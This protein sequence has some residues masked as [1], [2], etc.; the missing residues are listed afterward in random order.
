MPRRSRIILSGVPAHI[1]QRGNNRQ[2]CFF[3]DQDRSFFL[4]HFGRWLQP[5][6]CALHAYCLMTNHIHLLLTSE[7]EDGCARLMKHVG[8]LHAQ[9]VN[10][11]Y[12]RV[13]TLWQGRFRSCVVQSED[14][15][16]ACYR[17]IESNP[18]RA[19]LARHPRDYPWS[20]YRA[21]AE[22][23]PDALL[24]PHDDYLRLGTSQGERLRAYQDLFELG[25]DPV[26]IDEI[27]QA[28]NGNFALG[29]EAFKRDM[30]AALGRRVEPGKAGRPPARVEK[31][32]DQLELQLHARKNVVCP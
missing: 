23:L 26:R 1:V 21:N 32:A 11:N 30:A 9:Y 24:T 12:E 25:L 19:G 7:L 8:Q 18:V 29:C 10:R 17:Y 13:G 27:R 20:S 22:G 4:F 16:L 5:S 3:Q 2:P 15:V 6:R 28:T 14:Y 31:S